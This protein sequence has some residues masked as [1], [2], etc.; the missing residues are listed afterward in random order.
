MT[1][2]EILLME[3]CKELTL[4]GVH[5]DRFTELWLESGIP[6][7]GPE[8]Y[9]VNRLLQNREEPMGSRWSRQKTYH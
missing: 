2:E 8:F 1:K 4:E 9:L 6:L 5:S 7:E 3:L